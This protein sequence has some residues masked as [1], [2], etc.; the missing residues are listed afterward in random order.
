MASLI[1]DQCKKRGL[2]P[3]IPEYI[4]PYLVAMLSAELENLHFNPT[5][6]QLEESKQNLRGV[7]RFIQRFG[8]LHSRLAISNTYFNFYKM[9]LE[10]VLKL[11][12]EYDKEHGL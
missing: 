3:I 2:A 9:T 5:E 7:E 4:E 6:K 11:N 12:E 10:E 8:G 1:T